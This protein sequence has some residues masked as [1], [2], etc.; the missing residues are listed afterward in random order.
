MSLHPAADM[1]AKENIFGSRGRA[2][3]ENP[4]PSYMFYYAA[5]CLPPVQNSTGK[6]N[7]NLQKSNISE[8]TT[9]N[10]PAGKITSMEE[11]IST[12]SGNLRFK[13]VLP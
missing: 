11:K 10:I 7:Q 5:K 3:K 6:F 8:S 9:G 13:Q 4:A 2:S 1:M 12:Y